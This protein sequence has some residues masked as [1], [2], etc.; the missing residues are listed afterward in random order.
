MQRA[1]KPGQWDLHPATDQSQ[2]A[3]VILLAYF[4]QHIMHIYALQNFCSPC[5]IAIVNRFNKY[6]AY[7]TRLRLV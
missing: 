1:S 7:E 5:N 2:G 6:C 3:L 4:S